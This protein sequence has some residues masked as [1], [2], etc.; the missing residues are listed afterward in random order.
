MSRSQPEK[1]SYNQRIFTTTN[2]IPEQGVDERNA[3]PKTHISAFA[4]AQLQ[5][6]ETTK[7]AHKWCV[8][9]ELGGTPLSHDTKA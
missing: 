9:A 6:R 2:T 8:N 4:L 1:V 3:I 5:R 7:T